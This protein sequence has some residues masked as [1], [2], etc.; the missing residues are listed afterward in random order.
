MREIN[1]PENTEG[2]I[3]CYVSLER[4][5][6][7][8]ETEKAMPAICKAIQEYAE[9]F[10]VPVP[11]LKTSEANSML[12]DMLRDW[13]ALTAPKALIVLFDETDVLSGNALISFLRQLRG[14]LPSVA[15]VHFPP[16]S[17]W[18]A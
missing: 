8:E 18:W 6:G 16:L 5:Q 3:A 17:P 11:E 1:A 10:G 2:A 4:C 13:S 12:S 14:A 15:Q 7:V 9:A